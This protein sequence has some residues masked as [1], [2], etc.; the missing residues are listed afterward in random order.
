MFGADLTIWTPDGHHRHVQVSHVAQDC[1]PA[2]SGGMQVPDCMLGR[3][4]FGTVADLREPSEEVVH[5]DGCDEGL[6]QPSGQADKRVVQQGLLHYC[7][8]VRPLCNAGWVHPRLCSKPVHT[9]ALE[10]LLLAW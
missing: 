4:E 2:M 9:R 7:H 6:A 8:L 3:Q 10:P 1:C 5:H